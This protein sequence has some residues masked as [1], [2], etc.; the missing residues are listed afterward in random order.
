MKSLRLENVQ[1]KC[2]TAKWSN[3]GERYL[4]IKIQIKWFKSETEI[5][6]EDLSKETNSKQKC[7]LDSGFSYKVEVTV[8]IDN[9]HSTKEEATSNTSKNIFI[10]FTE[11]LKT[12]DAL[13]N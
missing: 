1:E 13:S 8:T 6:S 7:Q 3:Q 12:T 9:L 10:C 4:N 2:L 11:W 5:H